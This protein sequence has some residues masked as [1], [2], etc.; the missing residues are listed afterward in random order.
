MKVLLVRPRPDPRSINLQSFMICEPLE[1]E[2]LAAHLQ[3]L[4]HTVDLVDLILERKP[5]TWFVTQASYDL[6]GL[7]GYINH[8]QVIKQLARDV[9][10]VSPRTRVVVG[11]VHAE[12]LPGDFADPARR[13]HRVG[14]RRSNHR[15][16][17]VRPLGGRGRCFAWGL[18]IRTA[19]PRAR[20]RQ[21]AVPRPA[22]HGEVPGPVQLHLPRTVARR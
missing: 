3:H 20:P 8:V 18:G 11:G 21:A 1:L 12:V 19:T 13:P 4:G 7:T 6:V 2:T 10:R 17:R 5:L 15:R 9:K 22:D 14:Q 16:D